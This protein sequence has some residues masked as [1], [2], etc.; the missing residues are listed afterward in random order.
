MDKKK[1]EKTKQEKLSYPFK[2]AAWKKKINNP[3]LLDAAAVVNLD[4][5]RN[6]NPSKSGVVRQHVGLTLE[7][8][9]PPRPTISSIFAWTDGFFSQ[10]NLALCLQPPAKRD[11]SPGCVLFNWFGS[12]TVS[13]GGAETGLC[14][15]PPTVGGVIGTLCEGVFNLSFIYVY[16][17]VCIFKI[18]DGSIFR[19]IYLSR[20]IYLFFI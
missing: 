8:T 2:L 14:R 5:H 11:F 7:T 16:M 10:C 20:S 9:P 1:L 17:D 3:S 12:K 19:S 13:E 6:P 4:A 15:L 18:K